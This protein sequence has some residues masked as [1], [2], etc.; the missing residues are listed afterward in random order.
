MTLG[1]VTVGLAVEEEEPEEEECEDKGTP[2]GRNGDALAFKLRTLPLLVILASDSKGEVV[3]EGRGGG[4]GKVCDFWFLI[5]RGD[6]FSSSF[7]V[8]RL[9]FAFLSWSTRADFFFI[10]RFS[11]SCFSSSVSLAST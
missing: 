3:E 2:E 9:A 6:F 8:F 4:V 11:F 1:L 5:S 7:S 10:S